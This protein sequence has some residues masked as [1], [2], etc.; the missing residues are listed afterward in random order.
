VPGRFR[1]ETVCSI[2][3][4]GNDAS[5]WT[6]NLSQYRP[7]LDK[8]RIEGELTDGNTTY[9]LMPIYRMTDA[10]GARGVDLPYPLGFT[11]AR[12]DSAVAAIDSVSQGRTTARIHFGRDLDAAQRSLIAAVSAAVLLQQEDRGGVT[13]GK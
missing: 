11:I 9:D 8:T 12:G 10:A 2:D 7:G 3:G 6:L 5:Q 13:V 1:G 4:A